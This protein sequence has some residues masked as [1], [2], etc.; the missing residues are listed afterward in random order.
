[1]IFRRGARRKSTRL[2]RCTKNSGR[3]WERATRMLI[4][5]TRGRVRYPDDQSSYANRI[6]E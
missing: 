2:S 4:A 3:C 5:A 6:K 1:M